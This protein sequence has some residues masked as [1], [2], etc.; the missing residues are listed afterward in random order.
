MSTTSKQKVI[1]LVLPKFPD[2]NHS[3]WFAR[4]ESIFSKNQIVDS[5]IQYEFVA[6]SLPPS[7]SSRLQHVIKTKPKDEPYLQLK[8]H[9]LEFFSSRALLEETVVEIR[10]SPLPRKLP[11]P[12]TTITR[13]EVLAQN[14][15]TRQLAYDI[16]LNRQ[17]CVSKKQENATT[18]QK[19][20]FVPLPMLTPENRLNWFSIVEAIFSENRIFDLSLKYK[21]ALKA[22]PHS[23]L[24]SLLTSINPMPLVD[25]YLKLN[26]AILEHYAERESLKEQ[27]VITIEDTLKCELPF[28]NEQESPTRTVLNRDSDSVVDFHNNASQ[29]IVDIWINPS[30]ADSA[31]TFEQP[32]QEKVSTSFSSYNDQPS[33]SNVP[34]TKQDII[35]QSVQSIGS[36]EKFDAIPSVSSQTD[37]L[38]DGSKLQTF[39][40]VQKHKPTVRMVPV[41]EALSVQNPKVMLM[42]PNQLIQPDNDPLALPVITE[43]FSFEELKPG[44]EI[45]PDRISLKCHHCGMTFARLASLEEHLRDLHNQSDCYVCLFCNKSYASKCERDDHVSDIHK[46]LKQSVA[47]PPTF[48]CGVCNS[49][50][51]S[52]EERTKHS[53]VHS[54]ERVS[55]KSI[56]F[57]NSIP[58]PKS[59]C[60]EVIVCCDQRFEKTPDL[61][62][63]CREYHNRMRCTICSQNFYQSEIVSHVKLR[64]KQAIWLCEICSGA[65]S[66]NSKKEKHFIE[67]HQRFKCFSCGKLFYNKSDSSQHQCPLASVK[68][69]TN[70]QKTVIITSTIQSGKLV[71]PRS[72]P[73][74]KMS[75]T[76]KSSQS[77][78]SQT[79]TSQSDTSQSDTSETDTS[80]SDVQDI[81][82]N[83]TNNTEVGSAVDKLVSQTSQSEQNERNS[84]TMAKDNNDGEDILANI[85]NHCEERI[86]IVTLNSTNQSENQEP[87][88]DNN[89]D[90]SAAKDL[91]QSK[92]YNQ[93]NEE[94]T[95]REG[96]QPVLVGE[97][98]LVEYVPF[99]TRQR[100]ESQEIEGFIVPS[101]ETTAWQCLECSNVFFGRKSFKNHLIE[102]HTSRG[103]QQL[104]NPSVPDSSKRK[105]DRPCPKSKKKKIEPDMS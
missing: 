65:F 14:V 58:T 62:F 39:H 4:V 57:T 13:P 1:K 56:F 70:T 27:E 38:N 33:L 86:V 22:L 25:P 15:S 17:A 76:S 88:C 79:D 7:L 102:F 40:S 10:D 66:D 6:K 3:S 45:M 80:Q 64:H 99:T 98:S 9:I 60:R 46:P 37:A 101:T 35:I 104:V 41:A 69:T 26:S 52:A 68:S 63:H 44:P 103:N 49:S 8:L 94:R 84:V 95:D 5:S 83:S 78:T 100:D 54:A 19:I 91:G 93:Y 59:S 75:K 85:T 29:P 31:N 89:D 20:V 50:F 48:V 34:H 73:T 11:K 81:P 97:P 90:G 16:D 92:T 32:L 30:N 105:P 23:L 67:A 43:A 87:T 96:D 74:I 21:L 12:S 77:D 51:T 82:A 53:K 71:K 24:T 47:K 61:S 55:Q 28:K 72:K 2:K 42:V 18:S 36:V